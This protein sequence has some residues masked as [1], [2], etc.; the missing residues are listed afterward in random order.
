MVVAVVV[1]VLL[2]LPVLLVV[3][4]LLLLLLQSACTPPRVAQAQT[5]PLVSLPQVK[6]ATL[7]EKV[8]STCSLLGVDTSGKNLRD[9]AVECWEALGCPPC[10]AAVGASAAGG[11]RTGG[12]SA[13]AVRYA[14]DGK[15]A[16]V[17]YPF[18]PSGW[19]WGV[20]ISPD[21]SYC[22]VGCNYPHGGS[23]VPIYRIELDSGQISNPFKWSGSNPIGVAIAPS[24]AYALATDTDRARLA[25][26]DLQ[27]KQVTHPYAGLQHPTGVA[28]S[29]SGKIALVDSGGNSVCRIDLDT[30]GTHGKLTKSVFTGLS[31]DHTGF[32]FAPDESY[33]LCAN[34]GK[35]SVARLDLTTGK[36]EPN[37]YTGFQ[38]VKGVAVSPNGRFALVCDLNG[39]RVGHI[40][41][42]TGAVSFPYGACFM[43]PFSVAFAPSGEFALFSCGGNPG[44]ADAHKIGRI[45]FKASG[46]PPPGGPPPGP[47]PGGSPPAA[48][49]SPVL[50]AGEEATKGWGRRVCGPK[51]AISKDGLTAT[52]QA[53]NPRNG[54]GTAGRYRPVLSAIGVASGQ[55]TWNVRVASKGRM[56]IGVANDRVQSNWHEGGGPGA[57]FQ[58]PDAWTVCICSTYGRGG[59][60]QIR[61]RHHKGEGWLSGLDPCTTG[62]VLGTLQLAF[63]LECARCVPPS[64]PLTCRVCVHVCRAPPFTLVPPIYCPS[65]PS[66]AHHVHALVCR[67]LDGRCAS[68]LR[69][70]H[71]QVHS[72]RQAWQG[73][74][75]QGSA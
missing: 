65:C 29:S 56:C 55:H 18:S 38:R 54:D 50:P 36:C 53:K 4:L 16:T 44:S 32:S 47:P 20:S 11:T 1:M 45:D 67:R 58:I 73:L 42:S 34:T 71:A 62:D 30:S 51:I 43:S 52:D 9:Q 40:D 33:A 41:L 68:G 69:E 31:C 64:P 70:G 10:P 26:I 3:V 49:P 28:I 17:S 39:G 35:G 57:I 61:M 22:L 12:V 14:G 15:L 13:G 37:K 72:Q 74:N 2:L 5:P 24:G 75:V 60:D 23:K 48:Q 59:Y 66:T 19:I 46:G 6:G 25:H 7:A 8:R 63:A 21:A 27:S